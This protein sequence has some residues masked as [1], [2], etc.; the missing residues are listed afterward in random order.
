MRDPA[1]IPIILDRIKATWEAS[2]DLRL[3][4]ILWRFVIETIDPATRRSNMQTDIYFI[5]D[6]TWLRGNKV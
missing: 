2:P 1:R 3:G 4:Q 5:E 6:D